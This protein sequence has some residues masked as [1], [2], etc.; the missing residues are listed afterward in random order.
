MSKQCKFCEIVSGHSPASVVY[1]DEKAMCF[2]TLRPIREGE[3]VVIP[4]EHI[5]HFTDIPDEIATHIMVIAQRVGRNMCKQFGG[6]R[7]GLVVHGF[8]VPHAHLIL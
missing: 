3:C 1:E 2:M 5:D 6:I 8:G 7:I 4:K